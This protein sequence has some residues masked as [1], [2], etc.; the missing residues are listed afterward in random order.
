MRQENH[1]DVLETAIGIEKRV[2]TYKW[3][4]R[5]LEVDVNTAKRMLYEYYQ[6]ARTDP[7]HAI[8]YLQG[9]PREGDGILCQVIPEE[10]LDEAKKQYK[11]YCIHIYSLQP[12]RPKD[13][14]I[15]LSVDF[16]VAQNDT[17]DILRKCRIIRHSTVKHQQRTGGTAL[18][19]VQKPTV[20]TR[21]VEPRSKQTKEEPVPPKAVVTK[22][23][24]A[25]QGRSTKQE[26]AANGKPTFF[27]KYEQKAAKGKIRAEPA[28]PIKAVKANEVKTTSAEERQR[29][30][31]KAQQE[32]ALSKLL[33]SD[34]EGNESDSEI[35]KLRHMASRAAATEDPVDEADKTSNQLVK[36]VDDDVM[37]VDDDGNAPPAEPAAGSAGTTRRVKKRRRVKKTRTVMMGKYMKTEDYSD[38]E[39]YSESEPEISGPPVKKQKPQPP[40]AAAE[41]RNQPAESLLAKAKPGARGGAAQKGGKKAGQQK[42]LL[43]FFGKK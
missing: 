28:P 43:S 7:V 26:T 21:T 6:T 33:D 16:D 22:T 4:S 10:K 37:D 18:A 27:D 15:L 9:E 8:Y 34:E 1:L 19:A 3:L 17:V 13:K 25:R 14:N 5:K 11:R 20:P 31:L 42:T 38:W 23:V 36:T 12:C 29:K 24:A 30:E 39:E 41:V 2:V 32:A 40:P 35:A